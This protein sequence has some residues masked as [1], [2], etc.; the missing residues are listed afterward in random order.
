MKP[1][2][3]L[4]KHAGGVVAHALSSTREYALYL[5]GNGPSELSLNLPAGQY[6]ASWV[7]VVSG[8]K[9][10]A[11]ALHQGGG[12]RTIQSPA[13]RNGIALRISRR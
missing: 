8:E 3:D 6:V 4:V 5:D 10:D 1:D 7:D 12:V 9:K 11:G 13:F 2:F